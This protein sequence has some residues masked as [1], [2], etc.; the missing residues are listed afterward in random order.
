MGNGITALRVNYPG[1]LIERHRNGT[2]RYRVRVEG[3]PRRR[4][5][6]PV[7]PDHPDFMHHYLAA[8]EGQAWDGRRGRGPVEKSLDWLC[9]RYLAFLQHMVEAGQMS[10]ATLRQRRSVL[11]RLCDHRDQEG[12]R[13]GDCHMDAPASAFVQIRDAWAARPGA[14]DNL[15]KSVRAVYSWAI[16]R[17]EMQHNPAAGIAPI[18]RNPKGGATAWTATDLRRFRDTHPKGSTARLWLTL[19][20]FTACRVGD[21]LWLGRDQETQR[22][23]QIWLEWQPRKRGSA[24]VAIPMLPPLY[25]ATRACPIIGKSYILTQFGKPYGSVESLRNQIRRWCDEAGL[26]GRSSHGVRKAVA[27]LMAEAGCSQH[28]IMAVMAHTEARTS[29]I[30]TKHVSRRTLAAEG[31]R[32]LQGLDW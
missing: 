12:T 6:L 31:M 22:E 20:A 5:T 10:A 9:D 17:G 14:A 27:E 18:N 24:P 11:R 7:D 1:L 16:E 21:A 13:Y 32:A 23:G 26:P 29:E 4:I 2:P 28:Q 19:Q 25:N 8:R 30:Y 3:D 15:V